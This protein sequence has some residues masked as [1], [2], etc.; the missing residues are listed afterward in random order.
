MTRE[1]IMA[2]PA[3]P[4][5]DRLV[6]EALGDE[7]RKYLAADGKF[8]P[9]KPS[10]YSTMIGAA[11][12]AWEAM[13]QLRAINGDP[14]CPIQ[15]MR[16]WHWDGWQVGYYVGHGITE[17]LATAPTV[18]LAICRAFLMLQLEEGQ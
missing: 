1:E 5:L 10:S 2:M 17:I 3:G 16:A 9:D 4:D 15:L 8:K 6:V 14:A 18:P 12:K 7:P 13:P 11:W